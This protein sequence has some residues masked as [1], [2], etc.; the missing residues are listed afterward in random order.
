MSGETAKEFALRLLNM[1]YGDWPVEVAER[2]A[3]TRRDALEEYA[4]LLETLG[5]GNGYCDVKGAVAA[6][7]RA[8]ALRGDAS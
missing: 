2:D 1:A 7:R 5:G 3:A 8:A 4:T 6:I